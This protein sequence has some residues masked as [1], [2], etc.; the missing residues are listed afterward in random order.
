ML[1]A[2][3]GTAAVMGLVR[4][5]LDVKPT[6]AYLMTY[7]EGS[8][9]ANCSFCPQARESPSRKSLLSR[10]IWPAFPT[11]RVLGG[12]RRPIE[13]AFER[14]CIQAVNYPGFLDDVTAILR[15]AREAAG[16]PVSLDTPPLARGSLERL[17]GAGLDR[18]GIPLD[19]ATP[20]LFDRVKGKL[21]GG[22]YRWE[23]HLRALE[24]A[25]EVFGS[26]RVMSNLIV[27]LGETEE[28]AAALIQRL[29]DT[30]VETALFAFTP[31]P[32]T[33]LAGRPQPPLAAYRR[34]QLARHLIAAGLA[35]LEEMAFDGEG[36]LRGF[37]A[38]AE[39]VEEV[40]LSGE[41]FRTSGCPGCNRPYYNERPS[42]P[43]YN[44]PRGLT[45]KEAHQEAAALGVDV[46]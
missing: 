38:D 26:G 9:V 8:C 14:V 28:E 4:S 30:G 40:L 29:T 20:E 45:R 19:A 25:V 43:L 11:E 2:S 41:A 22:P 6:T 17:R 23:G 13:G 31:V 21:A 33:A 36:R 39:A 46:I 3:V 42:G 16:L 10:V 15:A 32:G 7:T 18:I 34:V 27:G 12:L 5:R 44:Y 35:R 37:G 1:R 24:A